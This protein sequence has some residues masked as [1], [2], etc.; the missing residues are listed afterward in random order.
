M[1]TEYPLPGLSEAYPGIE[2]LRRAVPAFVDNLERVQATA[3]EFGRKHIDPVALEIDERIARD[4]NYFPW[5]IVHRAAEYGYL[6]FVLPRMIGGGGFT[7]LG[8]AILMEELCAHC[9]GIGNIIGA[10]NLGLS[11]L[12]VGGYDMHKYYLF[13][14]DTVHGQR[15]GHP[16]LWAFALTEPDAGSDV[17]DADQT[18]KNDTITNAR[19]TQGGYV[20]N[21]RKIFISNGSVARY[22]S[23]YAVLD[24]TDPAGTMLALVVPND[25]PGFSVARVELKMGQ[26]ACPAAEL[27][28]NDVFVP[29]T[30]RL[31]PE[32]TGMAQAEATASTSRGPVG[33]IAIGIARGALQRVWSYAA[34][35]VI[36]D[37]RLIDEQWVQMALSD[38]MAQ[39][40]AARQSY[41]MS[42]LM[43]DVNNPVLS[44][45]IGG[46]I[47][48]RTLVD[49]VVYATL[50]SSLVKSIVS[51]PS[52]NATIT[53]F[54][55]EKDTAASRR[56]GLLRSALASAAKIIGSDV[57]MSV[58]AQALEI[59]G[60]DGSRRELGL[61]KCFRDAK[62]TQI[63]EGTNQINRL[64]L[65]RKVSRLQNQ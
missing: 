39:I 12:A 55:T 20:L 17:W 49:R 1:N 40:H 52:I 47:N 2:L 51:R 56:S 59:A 5:D 63:Y 58:T 21:G 41:F 30:H 22:I 50:N 11:P 31:G 19:R 36:G 38:M 35:K 29:E 3:R 57:A 60:V 32:G 65:F 42:A 43:V 34:N 27:E 37:H 15:H 23:V 61:E 62:I 26:R 9:A 53:K 45:S 48:P 64:N 33:A 25:T 8:A 24:R 6:T 44:G 18:N 7:S 14:K 46:R 54:F 16:V 4:H 10:S 13:A 28:F